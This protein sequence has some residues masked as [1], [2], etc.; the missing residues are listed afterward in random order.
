[1]NIFL[2]RST[3]LNILAENMRFRSPWKVEIRSETFLSVICFE[4]SKCAQK[5]REA[6]QRDISPFLARHFLLISVVWVH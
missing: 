3:E 1:M 5:K 2:A 6:P 4:I